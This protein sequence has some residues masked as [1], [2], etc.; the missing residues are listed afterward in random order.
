MKRSRYYF[1]FGLFLFTLLIPIR[2]YAS[3]FPPVP[4]DIVGSK[5]YIIIYDDVNERFRLYVAREDNEKFV[6]WE[7][8]S[9]AHG[10]SIYCLNTYPSE[11]KTFLGYKVLGGEWVYDSYFGWGKSS[12]VDIRYSKSNIY[13]YNTD[14]VFFSLPPPLIQTVEELPRMVTPTIT[15]ITAVGSICLALLTGSLVLVPKLVRLFQR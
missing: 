1:I 6:V 11:G 12:T 13:Y 9:E 4:S 3:S 14:D 7:N 8:P 10:G 2:S 15:T 5:E